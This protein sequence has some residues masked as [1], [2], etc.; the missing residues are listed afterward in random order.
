MSAQSINTKNAAALATEHSTMIRDKVILVTGVSPGGLGEEYC[1][2]VAK[3]QPKLL[4]LASRNADKLNATRAT[5]LSES[6]TVA[7]KI[8]VL[9]LESITKAAVAAETVMRWDDVPCIDI[10]VNNAGIMAVD[11][12]LTS[13]GFERQLAVNYL[14]SWVFTNTLIPKVLKSKEPRI[15]FVGSNGH[16]WGPMRW[17]DYNFQVRLTKTAPTESSSITRLIICV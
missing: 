17:D 10:V 4:I 8:L 5:L 2:T 1:F 9:D 15:V 11:F 16:R 3:H 14:S 6:P 7:V 13:D 12:A